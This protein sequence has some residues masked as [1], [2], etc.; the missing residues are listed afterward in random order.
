MAAP[1]G[2]AP[3]PPC[4]PWELLVAVLRAL[5]PS[6][7]LALELRVGRVLMARRPTGGCLAGLPTARS[8]SSSS[9]PSL[10][11]S[12]ERLACSGAGAGGAGRVR[13]RPAAEGAH[14]RA[15]R[16]CSGPPPA[17]A[18]KYTQRGGSAPRRPA[19]RPH[20]RRARAL[21]RPA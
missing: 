6:K 9:S 16:R 18:R 10:L 11:S 17:R 2:L 4:A 15:A 7:L 19:Q 5:P 3:A 20:L 1:P 13:C 12:S 14:A 8:D 21:V